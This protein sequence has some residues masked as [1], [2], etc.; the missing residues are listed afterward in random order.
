V[1]H[2]TG[3]DHNA[4]K[5]NSLQLQYRNELDYKGFRTCRDCHLTR[6]PDGT[7]NPNKHPESPDVPGDVEIHNIGFDEGTQGPMRYMSCQGCHIPYA[8]T[9]GLMFRN[10][11]V[12]GNVAWTSQYLSAD[13][14]DPTNEDKSKWY[15][16]LMW[17][18]DSDGEMRLFPVSLWINIYFGDWDDNGTPDDLSDDIV[19]P[20]YTWRVAQVVGSTPLPG[21]RDDDGDGRIEIDRP[22]ELLAYFAALKGNDSNGVPVATRPVLVR[23]PRVWYEDPTTPTGVNSF[24]HEGTG[25]PM[26]SSPYIWEMDHNVLAKTEAWGAGSAP[27]SCN[28]CHGQKGTSPVFDR[29]VLVDPHGPNGKPEYTTV[30]EMTG[31][32]FHTDIR[33]KDYFGENLTVDSTQPYSGRQTCGGTACHDVA[34]ISNGLVFQQGRTDAAGNMIMHDDFNDDGRWWVRSGGM[35]GRTSPGGGGLNR[36]FAGKDNLDASSIDMTAYFWAGYCGGCHVGGGGAEFDRDGARFFDVTTGQFGYETLG[37]S[38]GDVT[39]DGDYAYVDEAD[40]TLSLAPWD[41]TG[42]A[43]PECLHCHRAD[44]TWVGGGDGVDMQR[45]WR[46]SV[47]SARDSLVDASGNPIPAFAS[48]GTAGQ[49]W[50]SILDVGGDGPDVLQ[51]DY[52]VGVDDGSLAVADDGGLVL[53]QSS[54]ARPP[55]DQACWGCHLPGGFEGKRGTVWFDTRDIHYRKFTNQNDE[56]PSNDIPVNE[57][58]VCNTCHPGNLDHNFA[59]GDSPYAQ[60]RNELD[61]VDFR[62]CRDCHLYDSPIRHPDAPEVRG[63]NDTVAVH[64][65]GSEESGPMAK[66][67]CQSC[68][69][70]WALRPANIVTDRSVTGTAIQYSTSQF[71]SADP[72]DPTNPDKSRWSP[73]LRPKI[74]SDGRMRFFPQKMEVSIFWG[75]WD[76]HGTPDDMSDDTV[77]PIILWRVRQV[78][79]NKPLPVVT[80]DNGDGVPEVNR[81]EEMVV[82]MKALRGDDSHGEPVARNPVLVKGPKVWYFDPQSPTGVSWFPSE[83]AG[84]VV[85]PYEIFGLDHNVLAKTNAWGSGEL[86]DNMCAHCHTQVGTSPVIDRAV[87]LDPFDENG[88]PVYSTVRQMYGLNPP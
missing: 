65:A 86:P 2:P 53:S 26:T 13:P 47:L 42:V 30:R 21:T 59:K 4:A 73:G 64:L 49:G 55:R 39:L 16:P 38:A 62:S 57:A 43:D 33:L 6:F 5:G 74:D 10:I 46:A 27:E 22:D 37:K 80:D 79:G 8:L 36:Q 23:G 77:Q 84:P 11:T 85:V 44:R 82:Y 9:A 87:L 52:S 25:I 29:L 14:L 32:T 1:C 31:V 78:T 81:P 58:T 72:I 3:L 67:A 12:P 60:F 20:I 34:R 54:L 51:I 15:P 68:H 48:A 63:P 88:E 83:G 50:F 66:I 19:A 24:V 56:D 40:G 18:Q 76:Q 7:P 70:P 61:W 69:V 71:L 28:V 75:D 17:K 45:E 35:Y 41:V